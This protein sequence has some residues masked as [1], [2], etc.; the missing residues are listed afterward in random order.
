MIMTA[1][2][3]VILKNKL[4]SESKMIAN[5]KVTS[6]IELPQG[7]G[8]ANLKVAHLASFSSSLRCIMVCFDLKNGYVDISDSF[9]FKEKLYDFQTC[10]VAKILQYQ[11]PPS[12]V[13]L[14]SSK[15]LFYSSNFDALKL[16]FLKFTQIAFQS[17]SIKCTSNIWTLK[18]PIDPFIFWVH[19]YHFPVLLC[20][21]VEYSSSK[22]QG[23][24]CVG[25]GFLAT[26]RFP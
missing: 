1:N 14:E 15:S 17:L 12:C 25:C 22:S 3:K 23:S 24:A 21:L 9:N 13:E 11:N 26:F 7:S 8:I 10:S 5:L 19:S 2:L 4:A 18:L 20:F 6:C 16:E